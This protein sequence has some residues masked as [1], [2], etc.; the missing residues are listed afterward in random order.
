MKNACTLVDENTPETCL[1]CEY[2]YRLAD[3]RCL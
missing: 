3:K 1:V 2:G